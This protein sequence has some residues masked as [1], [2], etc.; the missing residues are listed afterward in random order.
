MHQ[1][2]LDFISISQNRYAP[3]IGIYNFESFL[4]IDITLAIFNESGKTH[5]LKDKL[6]I[7]DRCWDI[8]FWVS[9]SILNGILLGPVD[10][11]LL[12]EEIIASISALDVG[13]M[14]KEL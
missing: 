5:V 6:N 4:W 8:S 10:S 12:R 2:F 3:V 11:L 9:L 13:A 7:G 1:F 14:V